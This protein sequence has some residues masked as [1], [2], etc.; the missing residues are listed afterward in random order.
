MKKLVWSETRV[1]GGRPFSGKLPRHPSGTGPFQ[2][3]PQREYSFKPDPSPQYYADS[4]VVAYRI[5]EGESPQ[6]DLRPKV[7]SSGGNIEASLLSDGNLAKSTGLPKA[8]LG[9]Q[10]W[11]Q[12][13]YARP[14]TMHAV[15]IAVKCPLQ[16]Q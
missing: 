9:Q 6:T 3:L 4:A 10:V 14:Q 13:E 11:V 2:D 7:T 5:P 1:E 12:L 15:T 8:P 16:S